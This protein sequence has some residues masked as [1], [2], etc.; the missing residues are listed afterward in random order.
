MI[1]SVFEIFFSRYIS[2]FISSSI[3]FLQ[4]H[5]QCHCFALNVFSIKIAHFALRFLQNTKSMPLAV[6]IFLC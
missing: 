5:L 6:F 1:L 3:G 2:H 4:N